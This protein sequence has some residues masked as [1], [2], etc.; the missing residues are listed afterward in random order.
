MWWGAGKLA[1]IAGWRVDVQTAFNILSAV[2]AQPCEHAPA[3]LVHVAQYLD[4]KR[5]VPVVIGRPDVDSLASTAPPT[6]DFD[7]SRP[8]PPCPVAFADGALRH[9]REG[10][11]VSGIAIFVACFAVV[12]ASFRP[13]HVA[14]DAHG[15]EIHSAS[16]ATSLLDYVRGSLQEKGWPQVHPAAVYSDSG[17]TIAV[18]ESVNRLARSLHLARRV[19]FMRE[20]KIHALATF[21]KVLGTINYADPLTKVVD[22]RVFRAAAVAWLNLFDKADLE[23]F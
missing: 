11:S 21:L 6:G 3:C 7:I 16:T 22:K 1:H 9:D 23:R 17:S 12:G 4:C 13:H 15:T 2:A 14:I 20:A 10:R 8:L 19:Y 18:A 5:D